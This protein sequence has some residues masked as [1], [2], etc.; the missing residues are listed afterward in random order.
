MNICSTE[1]IRKKEI[2]NLCDGARLGC[3]TDFEISICDAKILALIVQ[4]SGWF[5]FGKG[6]NIIIP[7]EKIECIGE[8]TILVKVEQLENRT[9]YCDR[10]KRKC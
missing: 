8:D 2:I 3:A 7:W 9:A 6:E 4:S 1:D 10:K 5:C